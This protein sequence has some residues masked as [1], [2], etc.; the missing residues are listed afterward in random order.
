[1]TSEKIKKPRRIAL[2]LSNPP[3][4]HFLRD[5]YAGD[6]LRRL[7]IMTWAAA[8][9]H[10]TKLSGYQLSKEL[11]KPDPQGLSSD[12]PRRT[13]TLFYSYLDGRIAPASG[14]PGRGTL[15]EAI[16]KLK[17]GE[18]A[19]KYLDHPVWAILDPAKDHVEL[20]AALIGL[21]AEL[22]AALFEPIDL[23]QREIVRRN[24]DEAIQRVL[25]GR[26]DMDAFAALI[27]LVR[28]Y[29]PPDVDARSAALSSPKLR[30]PKG[31]LKA[32][33]ALA[34]LVRFFGEGEPQKPS[35]PP[36]ALVAQMIKVGRKAIKADP[37]FAFVAAPLM[38][39]ILLQ[40]ASDTKAGKLALRKEI[41]LA[42]SDPSYNPKGGLQNKTLMK[43]FYALM[44]LDLAELPDFMLELMQVDGRG[45]ETDG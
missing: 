32:D 10:Y 28:S 27:G 42:R 24:D 45:A 31:A 21:P 17:G 22:A 40:H 36:S 34:M 19:A 41:A 12:A 7:R 9:L 35:R 44:L 5:P 8:A 18:E 26:S 38:N 16:G 23:R 14:R 13:A 37:A 43:H 15:I 20:N 33:P 1:L 2:S 11:W 39:Y 6:R 3:D 30:L 29:E 4:E 25:A